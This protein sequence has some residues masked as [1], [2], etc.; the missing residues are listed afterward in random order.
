MEVLVEEQQATTIGFL[1]RAVARF[2]G[3]GVESRQVMPNNSPANLSRSFAK[4][5]KALVLKH[6]RNRP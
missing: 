5:C 3:Q 4:A 1:S 2:N 6:I